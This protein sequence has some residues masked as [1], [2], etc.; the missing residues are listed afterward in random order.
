MSK[1][2]S[3]NFELFMT[4]FVYLQY[5]IIEGVDVSMRKDITVEKIMRGGEKIFLRHT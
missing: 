1:L 5:L 2:K 3:H 4:I